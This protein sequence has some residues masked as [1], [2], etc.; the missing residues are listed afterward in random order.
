MSYL[1]NDPHIVHGAFMELWQGHREN[2]TPVAIG[3]F[4]TLGLIDRPV[5]ALLPLPEERAQ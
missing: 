5:S 2:L 1:R 3:L 4:P